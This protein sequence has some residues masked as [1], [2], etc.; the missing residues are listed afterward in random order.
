MLFRV[1][2]GMVLALHGMRLK[3]QNLA[4]FSCNK[5]PLDCARLVCDSHNDSFFFYFYNVQRKAFTGID[6]L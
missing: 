4:Y 3:R 2:A 6:W 1:G 5:P